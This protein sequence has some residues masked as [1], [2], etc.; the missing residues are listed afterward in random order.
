MLGKTGK[1]AVSKAHPVKEL[2]KE[3]GAWK[4]F[5]LLM[6]K[7]FLQQWRHRIQTVVELLLPVATLSLVI[8]LRSQIDPEVR[9]VMRYP[10]IPAHSMFYS[11]MVLGGL[12]ISPTSIFNIAYSPESALLDDVVRT[13]AAKLIL[14]NIRDLLPGLLPVEID[15]VAPDRILDVVKRLINVTAYENSTSLRGLYAIEETT[16]VVLAAVEFDDSLYGTTELPLNLSYALRFPERPRLNSLFQQGGQTWRTE[17]LFPVFDVPGPRFPKSWEGGN[18]PGYVNEM[19]IALQQV[20]STELISRVTGQDL[21]NFTVNIQRYPHPSYIE[22]LATEALQVLF[23]TFIMLSFSYTAV[24]IVKS[25]VVEKEMQ[26]KE[27]MKIMGLPTWLHWTAWFCKQFIYL[28]IAAVLIVIILKVNMFTTEDGFTGYA[29]L[30]NTP[31]TVLFFYIML[32]L[33]CT[34]FFCFMLSSFFSKAS[35]AALF[36]GLIWFLTY[37][38]SFLLS[39]DVKMSV[40]VQVLTCFSINS[41]MSYGFQLMIAQEST[42]GLQW[43]SFWESPATESSR[44]LFGHVVVMLVLDCFVYML[45]AL[46]MEQVL[47]GPFGT[48]KPWYFPVQKKFWFPN[49]ETG[50]VLIESTEQNHPKE[51]IMEKDPV[52]LPVGVKMSNLTKSYGNHV[53]VN[54]LSLNIYD[55]QI[56][57]LLGHNGAGKSTTISMLTGNLEITRGSVTV[58][59]YDIMSQ[60]RLA[61]SHIG[62]CPQ[63]NVLFNELTVREHLVFFARLKGFEGEQLDAEVDSLITKLELDDKRDYQAHGLS[64]G[65]KRRLSVGIALSGAAR[66]VLLDEPTSGMDP[67]SR[68]ALWD[69]LQKEKKDRSM[70]LTT[71]FMDEADILGDRIAIMANGRLQC[72]GSPYFLK[73]NYGVGYTLVVVKKKGFQLNACTE[74]IKRYMPSTII[75]EDRGTEVSY[76]LGMEYA[77]LF[78]SMLSELEAN[79]DNIKY[80][81]YGLVATSLEDV[82]MTVGSDVPT[83]DL[84][85]SATTSDISCGDT[86]ASEFDS[87][88][89][90]LDMHDRGKVTGI[91]LIWQHVRAMWMKLLLVWRRSFP[92]L[93]LMVFGLLLQMNATLGVMQFV[94]SHTENIMRRKLTLSEGFSN[95]ETLLTFNGSLVSSIGRLAMNAYQTIFLSAGLPTMDLTVINNSTIDDYYL[96]RASTDILYKCKQSLCQDLN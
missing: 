52:G 8:L 68:R 95:T 20:V 91:R 23:A 14:L 9:D 70:I 7:N 51:I 43:G 60:T 69:L 88:L 22:D 56:T 90:R 72:V 38:P 45:V 63:H 89:E 92:L 21:T 16:R 13:S 78:E 3:A 77:H 58:A 27:T 74:L 85:D 83:T 12:N 29:I 81:N 4:K 61:R 32:Y 84:D 24:N 46:Y 64:G 66:V 18:D 87:S 31:W 75:K 6:W 49:R 53:A 86:L 35:T 1:M 67:A 80:N 73:N 15:T 30:T 82:F 79:I 47:P 10:P 57:V 28:L 42:G 76:C 19:F 41:A 33:T 93:F 48:P 54:D 40:A 50:L 37:I 2:R 65:Q 5:R 26:L 55:D 39:L 94:V 36:T 59:G 34:I 62:L 96:Q 25:I 71:H 44:F 17:L 11:Q